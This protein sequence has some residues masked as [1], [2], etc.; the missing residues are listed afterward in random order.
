MAI[1]LSRY[2]KDACRSVPTA[3]ELCQHAWRPEEHPDVTAYLEKRPAL[4]R[5]V[6]EIADVVTQRRVAIAAYYL[7]L[8][9]KRNGSD[10]ID[11]RDQEDWYRAEQ[12]LGVSQPVPTLNGK[13]RIAA[14]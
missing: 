13:L 9:R 14:S 6:E 2:K 3:E 11:Y 4:G 12:Q 10:P 7:Y 8:E 1:D 5:A